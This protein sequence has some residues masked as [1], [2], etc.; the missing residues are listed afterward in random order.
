MSPKNMK[1][2]Y[3]ILNIKQITSIRNTFQEDCQRILTFCVSGDYD[4]EWGEDDE[5]YNPAKYG[6]KLISHPM[7]YTDTQFDKELL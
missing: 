7:N 2:K 1:Y 5:T 4:P 6:I 3:F